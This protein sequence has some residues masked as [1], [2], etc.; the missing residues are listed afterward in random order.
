[1]GEEDDVI[2]AL[3]QVHLLGRGPGSLSF[4]SGG[5]ARGGAL[6]DTFCL[7]LCKRRLRLFP[8]NTAAVLR[9]VVAPQ[10]QHW[11]CSP[12][13]STHQRRGTPHTLR[14][15][16]RIRSFAACGRSACIAMGPLEPRT[17]P[18]TLAGRTVR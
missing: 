5:L 11:G 17:S 4:Q 1:M 16:A 6:S 9:R 15:G 14:T 2:P 7:S 12:V 13:Y 18:P 10:P 8:L 3:A